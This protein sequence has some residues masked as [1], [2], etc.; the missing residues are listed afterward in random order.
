MDFMV[1][2]EFVGADL[3]SSETTI[4]FLNQN[5]NVMQAYEL[6]FCSDKFLPSFSDGFFYTLPHEN[7]TE[8]A[9]LTENDNQYFL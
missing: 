1:P 5:E 6:N 3:V 4:K 8:P 9:I 7:I 2:V